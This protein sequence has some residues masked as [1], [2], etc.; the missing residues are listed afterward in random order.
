[1]NTRFWGN[2]VDTWLIAI[3][4]VVG[5]LLVVTLARKILACW[6]FKR[7]RDRDDDVNALLAE[8]VKNI[9]MPIVTVL[10][11]YVGSKGLDIKESVGRWIVSFAM[12][13]AILQIAKWGNVFISFGLKK[14]VDGGK[15]KAERVATFR[16]IAF[17]GRIGL[18]TVAVLIALDN[19][20]GVEVTALVASLGIG[21]IAVAVALQNILGDIFASLSIL[22]D[23]P[24]ASGDFIVVGDHMGTVEIIGLKTTRIRSLSGEQLV[25]SN[26]DLL[27]SRIRN[28]RRMAERRVVFS[29]NVVYQT[30]YML[31]IKIPEIIR[32]IVEFQSQVR[33]DRTH[34]KN[35]TDFSVSFETVYYV[36]SPDYNLYMDIQQAINLEIFRQFETQNIHFAY[37]TQTVF[38]LN[39]PKRTTPRLLAPDAAAVI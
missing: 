1:M 37:P 16:A 3:G 10:L 25:F 4:I 14:F 19:V 15:Q 35:Y 21:G 20:P 31:L 23:R 5:I 8:L 33:F 28:Y 38:V 30:E 13:S 17:V 2:S 22:L 32:K 6:F 27:K 39:N 18:F 9:S 36:L 11:V 34:F 26:N 24:F 29:I 7:D 12:I